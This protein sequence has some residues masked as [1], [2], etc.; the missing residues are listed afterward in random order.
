MIDMKH[1]KY[2]DV[3]ILA[4]IEEAMGQYD[5][6]DIYNALSDYYGKSWKLSK[7]NLTD[8]IRIRRDENGNITNKR[9]TSNV[10][11]LFAIAYCFNISLDDIVSKVKKKDTMQLIKKEMSS[12][13]NISKS[14]KNK[15]ELPPIPRNLKLF[16]SKTKSLAIDLLENRLIE[17]GKKCFYENHQLDLLVMTLLF[18]PTTNIKITK[19]N[20]RIAIIYKDNTLKEHLKQIGK[21]SLSSIKCITYRDLEISDDIHID[22]ANQIGPYR[23]IND[24]I[25]NPFA[26][27]EWLLYKVYDPFIIK[28]NQSYFIDGS[29]TENKI[30]T[31]IEPVRLLLKFLSRLKHYHIKENNNSSELGTNT[32]YLLTKYGFYLLGAILFYRSIYQIYTNKYMKSESTVLKKLYKNI[33]DSLRNL[34]KRFLTY[35]NSDDEINV[36]FL[37]NKIIQIKEFLK[38]STKYFVCNED[39][40]IIEKQKLKLNLTHRD[41]KLFLENYIQK[42]KNMRFK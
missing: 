24:A 4:K 10:G 41:V 31:D 27:S 30:V 9:L 29:L 35:S 6:D 2:L 14:K 21:F 38:E 19:G 42:V 33:N 12:N 7:E 17:I 32:E 16:K 22:F 25:V 36:V 26:E 34:Q 11:L 3:R 39:P 8:R 1:I 5:I 23:I 18:T 15:I 20:L 37:N 13:K 40:V 28:E